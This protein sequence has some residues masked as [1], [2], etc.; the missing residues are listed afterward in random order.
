MKGAAEKE[1]APQGEQEALPGEA[2]MKP[3]PQ[4]R[5]VCGLVAKKDE[6]AVPTGHAAQPLSVDPGTSP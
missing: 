3:G 1:P 5:H 2:A 4:T 6:L